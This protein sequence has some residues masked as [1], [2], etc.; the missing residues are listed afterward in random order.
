MHDG[1]SC[2]NDI[3]HSGKKKPFSRR[4]DEHTCDFKKNIYLY[5][6]HNIEI[7]EQNQ[8]HIN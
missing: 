4:D 7:I 3:I 2:L 6:K 1:Q 5:T 8:P